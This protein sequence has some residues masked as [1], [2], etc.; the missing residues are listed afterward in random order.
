MLDTPPSPTEDY[1]FV[2]TL[3]LHYGCVVCC[4]S[5]LQTACQQLDNCQ[6][7]A[8][9]VLLEHLVNGQ[10]SVTRENLSNGIVKAQQKLAN[11][12]DVT[13]IQNAGDPTAD[14]N[15]Q[16][17]VHMAESHCKQ[18]SS[19]SGI[20]V[21]PFENIYLIDIMKAKEAEIEALKQVQLSQVSEINDLKMRALYT[22]SEAEENS[23]ELCRKELLEL[24]TLRKNHTL[25]EDKVEKLLIDLDHV[26]CDKASIMSRLK[27]MGKDLKMYKERTAE[28]AQ[29]VDDYNAD[30]LE[31]NKQISELVDTN[32]EL[33]AFISENRSLLNRNLESSQ[34]SQS[35]FAN[36]SYSNV[37]ATN[38]G[39][40]II[41]IQLKEKELENMKLIE[42]LKALKESQVAIR[43]SLRVFLEETSEIVSLLKL[44]QPQD[45]LSDA[46]QVA[47]LFRSMSG[48][49]LEKSKLNAVVQAQKTALI[50]C[51]DDR[52]KLTDVLT[53]QTRRVEHMQSELDELRT[54]IKCY[55]D[56]EKQSLESVKYEVRQQQELIAVLK[57]EKES[58]RHSIKKAEEDALSRMRKILKLN[59]SV[60]K[61]KF[62]KQK[63]ETKLKETELNGAKLFTM[64]LDDAQ[65]ELQDVKQ[66]LN[67]RDQLVDALQKKNQVL[68]SRLRDSEQNSQNQVKINEGLLVKEKETWQRERSQMEQR[69]Q[70]EKDAIEAAIKSKEHELDQVKTANREMEA[71]LDVV[72]NN[73]RPSATAEEHMKL[74]MVSWRFGWE[75]NRSEI[76]KQ[77]LINFIAQF[78]LG[79]LIM[80]PPILMQYCI[81][82]TE[83]QF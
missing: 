9:T 2:Y 61:L 33:E 47:D 66:Q 71:K 68:D 43:E 4:N 67:E 64:K 70:M 50:R 31:K 65:K 15:P 7:L 10:L 45:I 32:M 34:S 8:I 77:L 17:N 36:A 28:L 40:C 25:L 12:K 82:L 74:K 38:L 11:T 26:I 51:K 19:K 14:L 75:K 44:S 83:Y 3:L 80:I 58:F 16:N 81:S 52:D 1:V 6:Q 24:R 78:L 54:T 41:D 79:P 57:L 23:D 13:A 21:E 60:E 53:A 18:R 59:L 42:E 49:V 76:I 30:V 48:I 73:L 55:A 72:C 35:S 46:R 62:E 69:H 5:D 29:L 56:S 22:V 20:H 63:L 37:M 39:S 27:S